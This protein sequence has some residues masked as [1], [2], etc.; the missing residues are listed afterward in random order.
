MILQ[1]LDGRYRIHRSIL[2]SQSE[3]FND[4]FQI[5]PSFKNDD[6]IDGLPIVKL[7]GDTTEDWTALLGA[8]YQVSYVDIY[9][10]SI[11]PSLRA[12]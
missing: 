4:M 10:G 6:V 7:T 8:L 12:A 3:V 9:L 11:S 1:V 5:P 2:R